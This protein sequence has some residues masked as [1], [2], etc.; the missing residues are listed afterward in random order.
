MYAI[1]KCNKQMLNGVKTLMKG[2]RDD[3]IRR[4]H[5]KI[6]QV[7]GR[8]ARHERIWRR[9]DQNVRNFVYSSDFDRNGICCALG[10]HFGTKQWRNPM[11]LG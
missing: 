5:K 6:V 11:E 1:C 4:R 7:H 8:D 3:G 2:V 9:N 10:T